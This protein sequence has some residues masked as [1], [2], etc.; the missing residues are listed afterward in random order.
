MLADTPIYRWDRELGDYYII[1]TKDVIAKMILKYSKN[2][3]WNNVN[4]EH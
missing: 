4:L 3:F 1:F 2:N